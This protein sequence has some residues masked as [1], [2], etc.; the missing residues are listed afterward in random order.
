MALL[1]A[2]LQLKLAI[3]GCDPTK[4][5]DDIKASFMSQ[6]TQIEQYVNTELAKPVVDTP[7]AVVQTAA[8]TVSAPVAQSPAPTVS[9]PAPKPEFVGTPTFQAT[10]LNS[11]SMNI[12]YHWVASIPSTAKFYLCNRRSDDRTDCG[13]EQFL[14]K[15][16]GQATSFDLTIERPKSG[17]EFYKIEITANG[18]SAVF[19]DQ[20][21]QI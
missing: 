16:F 8:P 4:C 19:V 14:Q 2:V 12:T 21:T 15:S 6:A 9:E 20:R 3:L 18:Q 7:P 1:V 17:V 5:T 13:A 11:T 10:A